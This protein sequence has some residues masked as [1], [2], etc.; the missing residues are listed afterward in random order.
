MIFHLG[1][2]LWEGSLKLENTNG[3]AITL[4]P[5]KF[6]REKVN[7]YWPISLTNVCLKF[8]TK[9]ASNRLSE[10]ILWCIH[11]NQ[12]GFLIGPDQSRTV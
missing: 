12:Y 5:K 11:K 9:L 7:H 4:V 10:K 6:I 2:E 8:L 1:N 3:Y